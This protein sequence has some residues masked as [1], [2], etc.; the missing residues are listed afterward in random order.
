MVRL[1]G[2]ICCLLILAAMLGHAQVPIMPDQF[3]VNLEAKDIQRDV[4]FYQLNYKSPTI[5]LRA[6]KKTVNRLLPDEITINPPDL[7]QF[8]HTVVL[9]GLT[10]N[11]SDPPVIWLAGNY[12]YRNITFFLDYDQD[13]DFTDDKGPVRMRAGQQDRQVILTQGKTSQKYM[14]SVPEIE[15][16]R[17]QK[18]LAR[19]V[20]KFSVSFNAGVG[21]GE[22]SYRYDDLDIGYPTNY[23]VKITEKNLTTALA[24]DTKLFSAGVS[25]SFQNHYYFTSHLDVTRGEPFYRYVPN[26]PLIYDD[27]VDNHVNL[28]AHSNNRLQYAVF[29]ALKVKIARAIDLQAVGRIGQTMYFNPSYNRFI[30][31]DN[32]EYPL[33]TSPFFE[34]ALRSEFTVGILKAVFVEVARNEQEWK[35]EGFLED[36]PHENFD[37]SSVFWKLNVG[38]RFTL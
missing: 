21:T 6:L 27:N 11:L 3:R 10:G 8:D 18:Y 16:K 37:S 7:S 1:N 17:I 35:P 2:W 28:D 9:V 29:G 30:H 15:V 20:N 34:L 4:F 13:R 25:A 38:Y 19:I 36:T 22:I 12:N 33:P 26:H 32:Q 24:Y 5:D 23:F 31:R 14:L